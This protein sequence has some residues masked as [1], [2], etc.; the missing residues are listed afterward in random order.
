MD[1][2]EIEVK[3]DMELKRAVSYLQDIVNTLKEGR[4]CVEHAE[5]AVTLNPPATVSIEL[6]ARKKPSKESVSLKISWHTPLQAEGDPGVNISSKATDKS[7]AT[8]PL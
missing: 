6:K 2:R 5:Q 7:Q 3:S 4:I 8:P 1:S